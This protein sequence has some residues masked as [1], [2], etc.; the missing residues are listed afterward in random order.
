MDL[1]EPTILCPL[2]PVEQSLDWIYDVDAFKGAD[3]RGILSDDREVLPDDREVQSDDRELLSDD[4]VA[5]S[6]SPSSIDSISDAI[7]RTASLVTFELIMLSTPTVIYQE[8]IRNK[9][10][11]IRSNHYEIQLPSIPSHPI[12]RSPDDFNLYCTAVKM[13]INIEL[14]IADEECDDVNDR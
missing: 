1:F 14:C 3:D 5:L 8:G 13:I 9:K 12:V 2:R 4:R 10:S 7:V 11:N 6:E